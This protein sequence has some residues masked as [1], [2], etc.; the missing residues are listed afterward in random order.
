MTMSS[1]KGQ[2]ESI[3]TKRQCLRIC[4]T[5]SKLWLAKKNLKAYEV[6]HL[7]DKYFIIVLRF[8]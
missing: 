4:S 1:A 6:F 7:C 3:D 2:H 8:P 5:H